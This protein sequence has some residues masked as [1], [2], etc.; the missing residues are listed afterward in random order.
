MYN[1]EIKY[2]PI[3]TL[4]FAE[5]NPRQVS[6]KQAQDI[7]NSLQRFGQVDP[8]VVNTHKER[9]NIIIGGNT[10]VMVIQQMINEN[11]PI[12]PNTEN[13]IPAAEY[14]ANGVKAVTVNL[15][16]EKEK[17]LNIRLNKNTGDFDYDLLAKFFRRKNDFE[18]TIF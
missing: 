15:P 17:E 4:I 12:F 5:Y 6:E 14:F 16:L 13:E 3:E 11:I 2:F 18:A 8:I 7:Q 9:K 1:M 10:R